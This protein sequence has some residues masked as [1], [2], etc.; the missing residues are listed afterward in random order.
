MGNSIFHSSGVPRLTTRFRLR[1]SFGIRVQSPKVLLSD[2]SSPRVQAPG[3]SEDMG[4]SI[5]TTPAFPADHALSFARGVP[6]PP[7]ASEDTGDSRSQAWVTAFSPLAFP[8]EKALSFA[9]VVPH[10][11]RESEGSVVRWIVSAC[12]SAKENASSLRFL[13]TSFPTNQRSISTIAI[14]IP[15]RRHVHALSRARETES[16]FVSS[17]S[18]RRGPGGSGEAENSPVM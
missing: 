10:P 1:A 13:L 6:H 5:F 17:A 16:I 18:P 11:S 9:R 14:E 2:G 4:D 8:A 15:S 3:A 12:P 7:G